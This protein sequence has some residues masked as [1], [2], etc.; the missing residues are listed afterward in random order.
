M[1]VRSW[2]PGLPLHRA[3]YRLTRARVASRARRSAH[4]LHHRAL[5]ALAGQ[6]HPGA[7]QERTGGVVRSETTFS[8]GG[9]W[10]HNLNPSKINP[11]IWHFEHHA[12]RRG[13]NWS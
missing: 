3:L 11:Y 13:G 10:W 5:E 2:A 7:A 6:S 1:I 12:R 8:H 4:S 9:V